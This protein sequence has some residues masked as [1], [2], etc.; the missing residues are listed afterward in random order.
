M[1]R[2]L[3]IGMSPNLGG[4]ESLIYNYVKEMQGDGLQFD[5]LL[6]EEN[7]VYQEE[8]RALGCGFYRILASRFRECIHFCRERAVFF[9]GNAYKY[10]CIW[11][12]DC[13]LANAR[14]LKAAKRYGIKKRIFHG[15]S[16]EHMRK[17]RKKYFYRFLH[18]VNRRKINRWA[19][20]YWA[21]SDLAG[22]F[23]FGCHW[24]EDEKSRVIYNAIDLKKYRYKAGVRNAIRKELNIEDCFVVGNV[25][26]LHF[27]KNQ[28]FLIEVFAEISRLLP[29]AV[30][31]IVG[32]GEER[33]SLEERIDFHG[34]RDKVYMLGVRE[35]VP[36]LMQAMDVFVL[37][38]IVE[39]LGIVLIE[40]QAVGL[41]TFAS[42][43][44]VPEDVRISELFHFLSLKETKEH[45][46]E[47]IL[48]T[49]GYPRRDIY[50]SIKESG[51]NIE[52]AAGVMKELLCG[53][54]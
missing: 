36:D 1:S 32:E 31:M 48:S 27:Q 20:D 22:I 33:A 16:A 18:N 3:V 29:Q 42:K 21:C 9:K 40:A 49:V 19:T 34:I 30:L 41:P 12:N 14:D 45:W 24:R 51:F 28:I 54:G 43:D 5:F 38:S 50:D 15:H 44:I 35:D 39:A 47:A 26:R 13:S 7:C 23:C 6:Y 2:V 53:N 8:L 52:K 4:V 11:L 17:D 46:A 25:G 10:D 37:T